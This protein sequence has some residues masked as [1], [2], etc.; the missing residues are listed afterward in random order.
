V[1]ESQLFGVVLV[2]FSA[3]LRRGASKKQKHNLKTKS[4]KTGFISFVDF[5]ESPFRH[6]PVV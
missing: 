4:K 6:A 5:F 1:T 3:S 2:V